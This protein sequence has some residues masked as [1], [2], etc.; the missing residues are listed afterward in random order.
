VA[1]YYFD[2]LDENEFVK[3]AAGLDLDTDDAAV[4]A[5]KTYIAIVLK[6]TPPERLSNR[7]MQVRRHDGT[8]VATV[9]YVGY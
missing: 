8:L 7:F 5:A 3:D 1:L 4:D 9:P 2:A 6:D